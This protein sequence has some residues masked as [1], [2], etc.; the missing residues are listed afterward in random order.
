VAQSHG[1]DANRTR[2]NVQETCPP[3]LDKVISL[4]SERVTAKLVIL[5]LISHL[6]H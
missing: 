1:D 6:G 2:K 5:M 4:K 3:A